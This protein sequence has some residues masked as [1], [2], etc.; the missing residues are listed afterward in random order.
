MNVGDKVVCVDD[1]INPMANIEMFPNW[2]T[3]GSTYTIRAK[4]GSLTGDVRILVEELENVIAYNQELG[5]KVEA[6][7]AQRR[8]VPWD[9]YI[10]SNSIGEEAGYEEEK[11]VKL[12]KEM[13]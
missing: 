5:G 10:L 4:E 3:E 11:E 9:D 1:S 12:E 13:S 6:G 7:F 2:V 8:F